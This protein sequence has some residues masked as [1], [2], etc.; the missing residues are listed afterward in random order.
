[1]DSLSKS[2]AV[3][4]KFGKA[5]PEEKAKASG[6]Y[7]ANTKENRENTAEGKPGPW[8]QNKWAQRYVSLNRAMESLRQYAVNYD[9]RV[10]Y[11]VPGFEWEENPV[12]AYIHE[13]NDTVVA[14][15]DDI[16]EE[17]KSGYAVEE[18]KKIFSY[19]DNNPTIKEAVETELVNTYGISLNQLVLR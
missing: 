18:L 16:E 10:A 12:I 1:M 4:L 14:E 7:Y 9:G 8:E 15:E 17:E 13:K 3:L 5:E 11:D 6:E 2:I 19:L